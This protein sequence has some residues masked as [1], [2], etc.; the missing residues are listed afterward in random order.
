MCVGERG[1]GGER[2]RERERERESLSPHVDHSL[3]SPS[4]QSDSSLS[5]QSSDEEYMCP[6]SKSKPIK[7]K[8]SIQP[9]PSRVE[10]KKAHPLPSPFVPSEGDEEEEEF[11]RVKS[12]VMA[13]PPHL[14]Q[15]N[16]S[17]LREVSTDLVRKPVSKPVRLEAPPL[18][19]TP[20]GVSSNR[21][22]TVAT[23]SHHRSS[24]G[25]IKVVPGS[26][27]GGAMGMAKSHEQAIPKLK[28]KPDQSF[29]PVVNMPR[30][31][32]QVILS[33]GVQRP[34]PPLVSSKSRDQSRDTRGHAHSASSSPSLHKPQSSQR[35]T[36]RVA[37]DPSLLGPSAK[38]SKI[39]TPLSH[40]KAKPHPQHYGV[41]TANPTH[42]HSSHKSHSSSSSPASQVTMATTTSYPT[43][44]LPTNL[45]RVMTPLQL[46]SPTQASDPHSMATSSP[47]VATYQ[48][49]VGSGGL[50]FLQGAAPQAATY[51]SSGGQTY[52][53]INQG[54][55]ESAQKVSVIMQPTAGT[56][57]LAPADLQGGSIQYIGQLD[58]PPDQETS[59]ERIDQE[60]NDLQKNQSD[61]EK[62]RTR[63]QEKLGLTSVSQSAGEPEFQ[64]PQ[65]AAGVAPRGQ[66][67]EVRG[68]SQEELMSEKLKSYLTR[69]KAR[70]GGVASESPL[71]TAETN[72]AAN[73]ESASP[74]KR[75]KG[76]PRKSAIAETSGSGQSSSG[77]V[78]IETETAQQDTSRPLSSRTRKRTHR[79][80]V[81]DDSDSIAGQS[82][83]DVGT[84]KKPRGRRKKEEGGEQ[85][86]PFAC[87]EC[88]KSFPTNYFLQVHVDTDHP[89]NLGVRTLPYLANITSLCMM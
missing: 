82:E 22:S 17:V 30:I 83:S 77:I 85:P 88:E 3:P 36:K 68:Q 62:M 29:T 2:E 38:P 44:Q 33:A 63:E 80:I 15:T 64:A 5:D 11:V 40:K 54:T 27:V 86:R 43:V 45:H 71:A 8:R 10:E 59:T 18:I 35:P 66:S 58:G 42:S 32:P 13:T 7:P 14:I 1:G 19:K 12:R 79:A 52:Q 49:A 72:S 70:K 46:V 41:V 50:I 16:Q 21:F 65:N 61:F 87:K 25:D 78:N 76:R 55:G 39:V 74:P 23:A 69:E 73:H 20:G 56:T 53:V 81:Q 31:Q 60:R 84:P 67:A 89:P 48:P 51:I 47:G 57:F 6:V 37:I 9:K 24:P 75:K 34:P 26:V 28:A 4:L